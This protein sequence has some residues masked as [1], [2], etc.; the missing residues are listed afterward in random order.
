MPMTAPAV[1][2]RPAVALYRHLG[3]GPESM[4][5]PYT[6]MLENTYAEICRS[7]FWTWKKQFEAAHRDVAS[8]SALR[9]GWDTYDAEPPSELARRTTNNI[10]KILEQEAMPPSRLLPSREG[11][12]TIS[13][14]EGPR[15]AEIEA[16]NSGEIAVAIYTPTD[17]LKV[18]E[19][20]AESASVREAIATIRVYLTA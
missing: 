20:S 2:Y 4:T 15:R 3:P 9:H 11:G 5:S 18:W 13:F 14:V 6:A 1:D 19:L 16:Y 8:L 10:L 17:V 12:I 7:N